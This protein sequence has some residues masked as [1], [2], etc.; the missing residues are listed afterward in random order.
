MTVPHHVRPN[1]HELPHGSRF[2]GAGHDGES[3]NRPP[4]LST[5]PAGLWAPAPE[6]VPEKAVKPV[7]RRSPRPSTES[8]RPSRAKPKGLHK[9]RRKFVGNRCGERLGYDDHLLRGEETCQRCRDAM[10][11]DARRRY[12]D[13]K[14]KPREPAQP[15]PQCGT[16]AGRATHRR[17]GEECC[18][19][20]RLAR[21]T[22]DRQKKE[23]A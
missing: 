16:T 20:C 15:H 13:N 6:V 8:G 17:N 10:A 22:A 1:H 7:K 14:A 9:T 4:R 3:L 12:A 19:P 5:A 2:D 21:N 11:A 23:A 18:D